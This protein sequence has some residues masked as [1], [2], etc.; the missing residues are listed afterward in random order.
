MATEDTKASKPRPLDAD[1]RTFVAADGLALL[2][3]LRAAG[4]GAGAAR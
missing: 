4:G 2:E 1:P 3:D